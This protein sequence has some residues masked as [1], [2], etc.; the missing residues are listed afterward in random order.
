MAFG[1]KIEKKGK[2]I[3]GTHK[4]HAWSDTSLYEHA[5]R[6]DGEITPD[7]EAAIRKAWYAAK[8]NQA[9]SS[10]G[11][12]RWSGGRSI[13]S[14]DRERKVIIACETVCLCD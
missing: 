8:S 6:Y 10:W 7:V 2:F 11:A 5:I 13:D 12:L 3:E 1:G 14:I 4:Q 9:T